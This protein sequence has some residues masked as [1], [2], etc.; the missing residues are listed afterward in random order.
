M[1]LVSQ[2]INDLVDDQKSLNSALLKT[3]VLASRIQNVELLDWVNSELSGYKNYADLPIYRKNIFN[4]LKGIYING[5]MKYSNI[6]IPTAGLDKEFENSLR[7]IEFM[8]SING[9]E[10][11]IKSEESSTLTSPIRAETTALIEENFQN[12]GNPYLR[13]ISVYRVIS[14]NSII[15]I[16][17]NVRNKL[18]DFMLEIDSKFGDITE[19][20]DLR[21]KKEEV[22]SIVNHIIINGDGNVLNSGDKAQIKNSPKIKKMTKEQLS[23]E[24]KKVGLETEDINELAEIIDDEIPDIA[25]NKFGLNVNKWIGKM[26]NKAVDGSW[27][28]SIGAAGSIL[29]EIVQKYYGM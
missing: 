28:V 20:K 21:M 27:N 16:V 12:M 3:K 22:S 14:K 4:D 23:T 29:A 11:L 17:N 7:S 19:I 15:E 13:V 24:L 25:N 6:Q 18:L 2:I 9:L 1:E 8:E 5:S 26:R 10:K